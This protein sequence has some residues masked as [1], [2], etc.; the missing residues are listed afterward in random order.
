MN[1]NHATYLNS[2]VTCVY[3][4]SVSLFQYLLETCQ[5]SFQAHHRKCNLFPVPCP[6][7]CPVGSLA[8][9]D[10][11]SHLENECLASKQFCPFRHAGCPFESGSRAALTDHAAASPAA[12]LDLMCALARQQQAHIDRLTGQLERAAL[13]S[14]D[15]ILT[16]KIRDFSAKMEEARSSE[17]GLELVSL[18]FFTSQ[19][20][21]QDV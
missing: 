2:R 13:T 3:F 16:W 8:R 4:S 14:Y 5:L 15:G 18:P 7:R 21:I 17:G 12:H 11:E 6:N 10:V 1:S 20:G 9:E 19:V